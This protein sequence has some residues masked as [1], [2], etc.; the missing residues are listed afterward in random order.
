MKLS[1]AQCESIFSNLD[2]KEKRWII[3][4]VQE[5]QASESNHPFGREDWP[6]DHVH[7]AGIVANEA[8]QLV[9]AALQFHYEKGHYYSMHREACQTGAM[10][11]RF[12]MGAPELEIVL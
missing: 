4:I 8:G 12:L 5:M 1:D 3:A 10:A 7:A 11:L 2:I 6:Q 9:R